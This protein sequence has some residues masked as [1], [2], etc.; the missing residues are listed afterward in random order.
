M[1]R[2]TAKS[3]ISLMPPGEKAN[4]IASVVI[5]VKN[6]NT[7]KK[8]TIHKVRDKTTTIASIKY[9]LATF[10]GTPFMLHP[11]K[12]PIINCEII[13]KVMFASKL[14]YPKT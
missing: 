3:P 9:F 14:K 13:K 8:G 1:F 12:L 6:P 11:K 10:H 2:K 7:N 4:K 5:S